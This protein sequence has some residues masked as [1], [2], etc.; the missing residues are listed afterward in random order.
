MF[1]SVTEDVP[2]AHIS[3]FCRVTT[4]ADKL[5]LDFALIHR[6]RTNGRDEKDPEE[7][8]ELLVGNVKGKTAI[9]VDDMIDTGRTIALATKLLKEAG[10]EKIFV[11]A[12]HGETVQQSVLS[13]PTANSPNFRTR[14]LH[15]SRHRDAG[16]FTDREAR[17]DKFRSPISPHQVSTGQTRYSG[18][19]SPACRKHPTI[20]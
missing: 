13:A 14:H 12:S 7:R 16:H 8:M 19:Q 11:L 1:R 3:T 18:R 17:G 4:I 5:G 9:L 2:L 20:S 6:K 10:C 15:G